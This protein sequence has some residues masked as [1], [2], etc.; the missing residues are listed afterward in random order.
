MICIWTKFLFYGGKK[1]SCFL[2][3][4]GIGLEISLCSGIFDARAY[5]HEKVIKESSHRSK[6]FRKEQLLHN[7]FPDHKVERRNPT[8]NLY[9]E[10]DGGN[11][12]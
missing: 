2:Y 4:Q 11:R 5:Q 6:K 8:I 10:Y 3:D 1:K 7:E 12:I 9:S